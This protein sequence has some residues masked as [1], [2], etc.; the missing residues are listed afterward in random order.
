MAK[1]QRAAVR[2]PSQT[3]DS[4]SRTA[5]IFVH[6]I[7]IVSFSLSYK[8]LLDFPNMINAS[9]GWHFQYLTIIGLTIASLTFVSGLLADLTLSPTF[10][11][12]KNTLSL[13]STP[14]EVL[15]S[16]LYWGISAIDK[17]LLI[18]PDM[19]LSSWADVG[20]HAMPSV[21]LTIDLLFFS[22][23]WTIT[24]WPAMGL[25]S[26][27]AVAYWAWVEHCYKH[28]G[29]YPYPLFGQLDTTQRTLLF[30]VSAMMMTASTVVLKWFYERLNGRQS[31]ISRNIKGA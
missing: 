25:S 19:D 9:Y 14:L 1:S 11:K 23:P 21:L 4:R 31:G 5:A 8:Y 15:I 3:L 24:A 7:G 16:V 6:I 20:F 30:T 26:T 10:F 12:I 2:H 22:P 17:S 18:P 29:F 13:C 28:N 27:L